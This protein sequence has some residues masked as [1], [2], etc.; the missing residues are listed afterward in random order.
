MVLK[1]G[2]A[3]SDKF[4]VSEL[5]GLKIVDSYFVIVYYLGMI[6]I[7]EIYG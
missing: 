6:R 4:C 2:I 7:G 1:I 5:K 3:G